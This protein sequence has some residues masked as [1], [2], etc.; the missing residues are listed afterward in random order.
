MGKLRRVVVSCV[1]LGEEE[2]RWLSR[3]GMRGKQFVN[4][5]DKMQDEVFVK[6]RFS[7]FEAEF[8]VQHSGN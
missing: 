8:V 5:L 1:L 3:K 2:G 6:L 4:P 7:S